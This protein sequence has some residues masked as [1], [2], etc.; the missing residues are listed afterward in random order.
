VLLL[1]LLLLLLLRL[2]L[3]VICELKSGP[4]EHVVDI[5]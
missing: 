3:R 5:A 1:L 4:L 2:L